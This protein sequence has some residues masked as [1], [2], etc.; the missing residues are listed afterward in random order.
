MWQTLGL[1]KQVIAAA[2]ARQWFVPLPL[3]QKL[4]KLCKKNFPC[5]VEGPA[6]SG[7]TTAALL[8][9]AD[10]CLSGGSGR[11]LKA[12][13][14]VPRRE[15]AWHCA[16]ELMRLMP[17][18]KR[19]I[20]VLL[21]RQ[22]WQ[23]RLRALRYRGNVLITTPE[24]LFRFSQVYPASLKHAD[25]CLLETGDELVATE[26]IVSIQKTIQI[27]R[28][29][30]QFIINSRCLTL[31][32]KKWLQY[33]LPD[34]IKLATGAVSAVVRPSLNSL[35]NLKK[36]VHHYRSY[37]Q[38]IDVNSVAQAV[39]VKAALQAQARVF[40]L[41]SQPDLFREVLQKLHHGESIVAIFSH[42]QLNGLYF[43]TYVKH[44]QWL[45]EPTA[46]PSYH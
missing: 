15:Q 25:F 46:I 31:A 1:C 18:A 11:G 4:L 8:A 12:I 28:P 30:T 16:A 24:L 36:W 42:H 13:I 17:L 9:I 2:H 41:V 3:Q 5:L 38:V 29:R 26:H 33:L 39:I 21:R 35:I 7:K 23:R 37:S 32:Q 44:V 27:L 43:P 45:P 34:M 14:L 22:Q 6:Y 20:Q 10:H 19:F 40:C